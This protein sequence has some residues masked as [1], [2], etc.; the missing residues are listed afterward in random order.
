MLLRV[1][2]HFVAICCEVCH[3]SLNRITT[4]PMAIAAKVAVLK[5]ARQAW[6]FV[7]LRRGAVQIAILTSLPR[8]SQLRAIAA[9]QL[10]LK[11]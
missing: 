10:V 3:G 8:L 6:H 7:A 1:A 2:R 11:V 5:V 9:Q 4:V